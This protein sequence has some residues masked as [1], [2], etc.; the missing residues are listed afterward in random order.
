VG[1]FS[2]TL[3]DSFSFVFYSL[4]SNF[5]NNH[6]YRRN[7]MDNVE[8]RKDGIGKCQKKGIKWYNRFDSSAY[9]VFCHNFY[10]K[11]LRGGSFRNI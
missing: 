2:K 1:I 11:T 3:S 6:N 8:W 4:C 10:W 9:C 7:S 5:C